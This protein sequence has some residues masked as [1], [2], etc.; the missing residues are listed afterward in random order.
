MERRR[1]RPY[2]LWP[3]STDLI[4]LDAGP[5]RIPITICRCCRWSAIPLP[6]IPMPGYL[7][8]RRTTTGRCGIIDPAARPCGWD[9]WARAPL[10]PLPGRSPLVWRYIEHFGANRGS[11][12]AEKAGLGINV[13]SSA[14]NIAARSGEPCRRELLL[15]SP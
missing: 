9:W 7:R 2:E 14:Q 11:P 13:D 4:L 12:S 5:T 8:M 3:G 15:L 6:S 10:E 1:L